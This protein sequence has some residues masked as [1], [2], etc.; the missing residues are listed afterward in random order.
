MLH[1]KEVVT[2]A[3]RVL[4]IAVIKGFTCYPNIE[5]YADVEVQSH[6]VTYVY[7]YVDVANFIKTYSKYVML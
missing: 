1:P 3:L 6:V 5:Q 7:M 4:L 2:D